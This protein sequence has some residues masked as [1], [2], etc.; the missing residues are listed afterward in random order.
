MKK[1][2]L[3]KLL[4]RSASSEGMALMIMAII[5]GGCTGIAA[6]L[7]IRLIGFIQH[8]SYSG[9]ETLFPFL[10]RFWFVIIPVLGALIVGPIITKF[11]IEAKGHGV[12]EVMQALILRGGRIRARVAAAKIA[13]SAICIGT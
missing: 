13:A 4:D 10:G 1:I 7:F 9:S 3:K 11:A 2:S 8:I 6:V 12:P 5:V